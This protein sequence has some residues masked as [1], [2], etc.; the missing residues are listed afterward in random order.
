MK[1]YYAKQ[2]QVGSE[3]KVH[4]FKSMQERDAWVQEHYDELGARHC[5][6]VEAK[7]IAKPD[8]FIAH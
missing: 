5:S 3:I 8:E 7:Q 4:T 1:K 2:F 6:A